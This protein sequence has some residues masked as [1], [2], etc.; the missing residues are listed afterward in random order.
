MPDQDDA[1]IWLRPEVTGRGRVPGYSRAQ[2]AKA[3]IAVADAEGLEAASM[4]RVATEIGAGPMSL[5]R[6]VR[7]KDELHLLMADTAIL[8][9]WRHWET[10]P[11]PDWEQTLRR[12]AANLRRLVLAHPWWAEV[13]MRGPVF[14]PTIMRMADVTLAG[15]DGLGLDI[16]EMLDVAEIVR[17]FAIGHAQQEHH[18]ARAM[19]SSGTDDQAHMHPDWQPYVMSVVDSGELPYIRR[20]VL[21]A[22]TPH[23]SDPQVLFERALGRII[24]GIAA[25]LPEV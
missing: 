6:Y 2:I 18:T 19:A 9:D 22:R 10:M 15:L 8:E 25:T 5:Y 1:V 21:D 20:I 3:A 24:A 11:E 13:M 23:E 12:L 7:N 4:R 16:D 14:G 17:T